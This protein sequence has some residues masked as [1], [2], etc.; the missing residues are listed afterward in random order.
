MSTAVN[1]SS[2]EFL[3]IKLKDFLFFSSEA[4]QVINSHAPHSSLKGH[5]Q[6]D[7]SGFARTQTQR[8]IAAKFYS[9]E[10]PSMAHVP[11]MVADDYCYLG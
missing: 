7:R 10:T 2:D 5:C 4:R 3:K 6:L 9:S 8:D 11:R 1:K